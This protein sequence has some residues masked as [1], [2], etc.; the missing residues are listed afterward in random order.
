MD[1]ATMKLINK[2]LLYQRPKESFTQEYEDRIVEMTR[3]LLKQSRTGALQDSFE[4]YVSECIHHF[5]QLDHPKHEEAP[6]LEHDKIL[7]PSKKVNVL[8]KKNA[9]PLY[10]KKNES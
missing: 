8:L 2:R 9:F 3:Q 1:D 7:Y 6:V 4:M 10:G 5:K